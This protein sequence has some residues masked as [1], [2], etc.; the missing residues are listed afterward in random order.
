MARATCAV[1]VPTTP[2]PTINTRSPRLV[3]P[4][5]LTCTPTAA[6]STRTPPGRRNPAGIG[7][8]CAVWTASRSAN[9]PPSR[10][11]PSTVKVG[12]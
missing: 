11:S 10:L 4:R 9:T 8:S 7:N 2:A 12:Q 1:I 5:R 3:P 6:G